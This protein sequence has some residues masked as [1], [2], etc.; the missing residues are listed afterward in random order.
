MWESYING[1]KMHLKL[2]KALSDNTLAAYVDDVKKLTQFFAISEMQ[3][4]PQNVTRKDISAF[5]VWIHEMGFLASSQARILSGIKNFFKY[6]MEEDVLVENPL[7]LVD[8]PKIRRKLPVVLSIEE[9]ELM[10]EQIDRSKAEGERNKTIIEVLYSC[11][12]R[13]SELVNLELAHV[14]WE[15]EF[16]RVI[17]KGNKE[18]LI[19]IGSVALKQARLYYESVRRHVDAA[20]GH[21]KYVFLNRRGKQLTRVMIFT[22]VKGLAEKAGIDKTIS[23]HTFRHSFATHLVE[24]GA[25]LRAVQDMLGHESITTTEIYTHLDR[26]HLRN[27]LKNFHPMYQNDIGF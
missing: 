9:I 6:L 16:V 2:E 21:S 15:E 11:G 5:I 20:P 10:M 22:I 4:V 24:N 25:D 27:T 3:R 7:K 13:V 26:T 23:P 12:L 8:A 17:G 18:R 14:Y 1:F 19:P